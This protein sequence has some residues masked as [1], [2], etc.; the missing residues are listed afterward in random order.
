MSNTFTATR[1]EILEYLD[2]S[3]G[4]FFQVPFRGIPSL[5]IDWYVF[6][7]R[8][9]VP[10]SISPT[11]GTVRRCRQLEELAR[12]TVLFALPI[13]NTSGCDL[14]WD[15]TQD[16]EVGGMLA[17]QREAMRQRNESEKYKRW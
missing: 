12:Y 15:I 4:I 1:E 2:G 8:V 9:A 5:S 7:E 17:G 6:G 10:V 13:E 11:M 3:G 16:Q 14:N